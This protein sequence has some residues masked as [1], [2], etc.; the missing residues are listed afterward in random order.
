M[1]KIK[2]EITHETGD[3][4]G[5]TEEQIKQFSERINS[6]LYDMKDDIISNDG[7]VEIQETTSGYTRF[8]AFCDDLSLRNTM[9]LKIS[10]VRKTLL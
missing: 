1:D 3:K 7:Y 5:I 2:V 9:Q 10:R 6:V 8:I 4:P